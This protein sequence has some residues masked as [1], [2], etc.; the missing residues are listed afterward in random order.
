MKR[1]VHPLFILLVAAIPAIGGLWAASPSGTTQ[2]SNV[3]GDD[4]TMPPEDFESKAADLRNQ[5]EAA[6]VA[7]S[8]MSN[9]VL[10]RLHEYRVVTFGTLSNTVHAWR[11]YESTSQ[12]RGDGRLTSSAFPQTQRFIDEALPLVKAT[13][14]LASVLLEEEANIFIEEGNR[15]RAAACSQEAVDIDT[16]L[17]IDI[18]LMRV[19]CAVMAGSSW[20]RTGRVKKADE[21][22]RAVLSYPW[23]MVRDPRKQTE[24][25][26]RYLEAGR[27]IIELHR[28][29]LAV[30]KE[31]YFFPSTM[32]ELGPLLQQAL[33]EAKA[34]L[35]PGGVSTTQGSP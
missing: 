29:D 14:Q 35:G 31:L 27:A 32:G 28:H 15:Q 30:L 13:P 26:D 17:A 2:S 25:K 33:A 9:L 7:P 34:E 12:T 5:A 19:Q 10:R 18:E 4:L 6:G 21:A 8:A 24:F 23:Y 22:Y 16:A 3:I 11:S 20:A 1:R